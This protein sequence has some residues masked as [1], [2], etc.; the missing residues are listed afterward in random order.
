[1]W[2][3]SRDD[4]SFS[5]RHWSP[6]RSS[7]RRLSLRPLTSERIGLQRPRRTH[8]ASPS[9]TRR[10]GRNAPRRRGAPASAAGNRR[11]PDE[12]LPRAVR[13][14]HRGRRRDRR[15]SVRRH[16]DA[17]RRRHAERSPNAL[18]RRHAAHHRN[19]THGRPEARHGRARPPRPHRPDTRHQNTRRHRSVA[20]RGNVRPH[21]HRVRHAMPAADRT[22][23][24]I[25]AV[26]TSGSCGN[27]VTAPTC[28]TSR[29]PR[30]P[31]HRVV[32]I[33]TSRSR[34]SAL[35]HPTASSSAQVGPCP[36]IAVT[37]P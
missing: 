22:S 1:M 12:S 36:T 20:R 27:G 14:P 24:A 15:P 37:T 30:Y 35:V 28:T 13:H 11:R 26:T 19:A 34:Q 32:P 5:F 17:P 10:P 18:P 29:H 8:S 25:Q 23:A 3:G 2:T 21:R 33:R 9:S 4:T 6:S 16:R 7:P 31:R